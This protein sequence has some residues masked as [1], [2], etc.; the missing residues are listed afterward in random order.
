MQL[1][2]KL[3]EGPVAQECALEARWP[4]EAAP[5]LSAGSLVCK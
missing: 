1:S 5:S 3:F 2:K 4:C